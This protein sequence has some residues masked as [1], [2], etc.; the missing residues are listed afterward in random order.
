MFTYDPGFMCT[1]SCMS[2][3]T[4]LDGFYYI[5]ILIILIIYLLILINYLFNNFNYLFNFFI[6]Y[7]NIY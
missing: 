2:T 3:I 7:I 6:D 5:Y 4:H 1:A